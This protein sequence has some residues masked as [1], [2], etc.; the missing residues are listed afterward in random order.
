MHVWEIMKPQ[1]KEE[2]LDAEYS[3]EL[4]KEVKIRKDR[5]EARLVALGIDKLVE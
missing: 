2:V 1:R 3:V 5:E 4:L